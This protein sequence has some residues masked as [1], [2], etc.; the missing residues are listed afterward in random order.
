MRTKKNSL[1]YSV[2][3][4]FACAVLVLA[5]T[6]KAQGVAGMHPQKIRLEHGAITGVRWATPNA[7]E[8]GASTD[9]MGRISCSEAS[10]KRTSIF[11]VE[12]ASYYFDLSKLCGGAGNEADFWRDYEHLQVGEQLTFRITNETEPRTT[13]QASRCHFLTEGDLRRCQEPQAAGQVKLWQARCTCRES[14]AYVEHG[15]AGVWQFLVVGRG[16]KRSGGTAQRTGPW[17]HF[18]QGVVTAVGWTR[19]LHLLVGSELSI[20]PQGLVS[21]NGAS[22]DRVPIYRVIADSQYFDLEDA[23]DE[24]D[25]MDLGTNEEWAE[26]ARIKI[27]QRITFH[28]ENDPDWNAAKHNTAQRI[29]WVDH[30]DHVWEFSVAQSGL[31]AILP[32]GPSF[33]GVGSGAGPSNKCGDVKNYPVAIYAPNPPIPKQAKD[34]GTVVVFVSLLVDPQGNVSQESIVKAL[35]DFGTSLDQNAPAIRGL[36]RNALN[37]VRTWKFRPGT[38]GGV[39]TPMRVVTKISFTVIGSP[40]S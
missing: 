13:D 27:G 19:D 33:G 20:D 8:L 21:C 4:A 12:T 15:K 37:T 6:A 23:C 11:R 10:I 14:Y 9:V 38:C 35:G 30:G 39:P 2:Q 16:P 24:G 34:L 5:G 25:L 40:G 36:V 17:I 32:S 1:P 28:V 26:D 3:A 22:V 7:A 29:A 18:Q 31:K